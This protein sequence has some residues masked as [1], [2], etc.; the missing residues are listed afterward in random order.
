MKYRIYIDEVGNSDLKSSANEEHRFLCLTGVI[1][2]LD[3]VSD[4]LQPELEALKAKY[5]GSHPDDP[6]VLHRK[7]LVQK[8]HPF[9]ILA[10]QKIS[11]AF[12]EEFLQLLY[13][14]DYKIIGVLIDKQEH[15]ATYEESWKYDPYHY[16][17][18][19]LLE[20]F[21]LFLN[22]KDASGDVMIESRG[23]K[24]D[25]RL[26][27]SFRKL[28]DE[29]TNYLTAEELNQRITSKELKVKAKG[30]NVAGLQLADLIAHPVR[31][32]FF[33]NHLGINDGKTTFSDSI[34]D[35]LTTE[36]FF[37]YRGKINGYGIKKLP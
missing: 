18:E 20:R 9:N 28:M 29:G 2:K 24:E 23:G 25:M 21:R 8:K 32:Y 4:V 10:D 26:K 17:Q 5:F 15:N 30:A 31:R 7:E 11:K 13:K 16:C 33:K 27:K 3:Y 6:V 14:W 22:I 34:I 36:K 37:K 19:I 12:D 35:I 1:F